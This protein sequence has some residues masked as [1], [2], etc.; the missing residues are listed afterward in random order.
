MDE[1]TNGLDPVAIS[2]MRDLIKNLKTNHTVLLSSHLLNEVSDMCDNITLI[3][4]GDIIQTDSQDNILN[5]A[6][7]DKKMNVVVEQMNDDIVAKLKKWELIKE[8][9]VIR[10]ENRSQLL[11]S[12][13]DKKDHRSEVAKMLIN[14]GV[15][16]IEMKM[17]EPN[18]EE[19]Y[20]GLIH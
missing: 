2:Q 9:K 17:D 5:L 15:I 14:S 19:A 20:K 3:K 11:I 10:E 13:S 8:L 18:L 4:E 7:L 6:N 1:P 16:P 12:F